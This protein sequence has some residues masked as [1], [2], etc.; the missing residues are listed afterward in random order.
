MG[1][2]SGDVIGQFGGSGTALGY[3]Q[4]G[5]LSSI[6]GILTSVTYN[7][8]GAPLVQTNANG[9]TTTKTYDANRFWL[10]AIQTTAPSLTLQNL[11]YTL[12]D[13]GM[14]TQV[15][16]PFG[17]EGW[18]YGYDELNRL[19]SSTNAGASADNQTWTYDSLGR[20]TNNSR[21]GN[22]TYGSSRPHAV[23]A[24]G[25]NTYT[26][27]DNNG[28]LLLGGGRS[29][30]WDANNLVT[31][32]VMGGNTTTFTYGP[33]G[34]RIKKTSSS[35]TL[36]YPF[37]DDY[38]INGSTVTKYFNAGFG[39]IA[40]KVGT[41][42]YWLHS[43]RMGSINA[44]TDGSGAEV[45]RRSYRSYGE[46]LGQTGTHTESLGYIG[47]RTDGET[48]LTYLHARY[49]DSQLGMFVSP[50][51][52]RADRNTYRYAGGN[53]ANMMDPSGLE[54]VCDTA[55]GVDVNGNQWGPEE[56][57]SWSE[58]GEMERSGS[59]YYSYFLNNN[60]GGRRGSPGAHRRACQEDPG[61]EGCRS[62]EPND[63]CVVD[64]AAS[65]CN[66][67][68]PCVLDPSAPGC[69]GGCRQSA[70]ESGCEE[71][72]PPAVPPAAPPAEGKPQ[73]REVITVI[74]TYHQVEQRLA[75]FWDGLI[76]FGE[77][78]GLYDDCEECL[79]SRAIGDL[80]LTAEGMVLT[81]AYINDNP[82][83]RIGIG[84]IAGGKKIWRIASGGRWGKGGPLMPWHWHFP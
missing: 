7:A 72:N 12:N 68:D 65:G 6:P 39:V 34:D 9:T 8:L 66:G 32:V 80:T 58:E 26:S 31:Q 73:F 1:S 56:R 81:S 2:T 35:T 55:S 48:G 17:T 19:T 33:D 44:M 20:I 21:I 82:I 23:T 4:A 3:D 13:A 29:L 52:A 38:E 71:G 18:T 50:D 43:D 5:R 57:C 76:P 64:P 27:Y 60:L 79:V 84:R 45:L 51:P 49:Y 25:S 28:N 77:F 59:S 30:T 36:R 54:M 70:A 10:T 61:S 74:P 40:K 46:L 63:P 16:S 75:A 24:A 62:G 14:A 41:A 11:S 53:P 47:Q 37:G 78:D 67:T 15:T 69:D 83:L 42:L 22:Y